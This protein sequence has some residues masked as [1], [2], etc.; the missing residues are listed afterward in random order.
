MLG[1]NDIPDSDSQMLISVLS[2]L[3]C[4]YQLHS[5]LALSFLRFI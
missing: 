3:G 1:G 2:A 5:E 4:N